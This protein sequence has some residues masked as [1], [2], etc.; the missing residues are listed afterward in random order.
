M[1]ILCNEYPQ[2][3]KLEV[4]QTYV[5][6]E[7]LATIIRQRRL[8]CNGGVKAFALRLSTRGPDGARGEL[9]G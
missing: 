7:E 9:A 3:R 4:R 2:V 6:C 8:F 1:E 5:L